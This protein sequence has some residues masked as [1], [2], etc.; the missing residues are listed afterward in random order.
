MASKKNAKKSGRSKS[1]LKKVPLKPI[2][3]LRR[4]YVE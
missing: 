2:T 3:T 4:G 1:R